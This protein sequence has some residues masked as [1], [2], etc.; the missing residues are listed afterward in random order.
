MVNTYVWTADGG[1]YA[2]EEQFSSIRQESLGG[3]Y[4][5]LG[6]GGI[7][8]ETKFAAGAGFFFELDA[9]F[10]G[11]IN[12]EVS[13]SKEEKAAFGMHVE[14]QGEGFLNKWVGDPDKQDG[15]YTS[16]LCPGKVETYRFMTFYLAPKSNN[17]DF[18]FDKVVDQDWLNGQGKY[19]GEYSPQRAGVAGSPI[20]AQ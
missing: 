18:F 10:G 2:E 5:F 12:V 3:S 7:Y 9:L 19:A 6:K 16:E 15:Y 4:H 14:V 20:K 17:F 13:K 11:H 8:A 1:F